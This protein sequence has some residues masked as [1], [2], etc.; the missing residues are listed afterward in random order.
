MVIKSDKKKII[1]LE[2]LLYPTFKYIVNNS[3]NRARML[4]LRLG[5]YRSFHANYKKKLLTP[6]VEE[7]NDYKCYCEGVNKQLPNDSEQLDANI[8]IV[9]AVP[10]YHKHVLLLSDIDKGLKNRF[11]VWRD[12]WESR[13]E[14]NNNFPYD[15]IPKLDF[16]PGI[17]FNA[18]SLVASKEDLP[19][20]QAGTYDFIVLPDL[21]L[22]RIRD[23]DIECFN[24]YINSNEV[25]SIPKLS[26]NDYLTGK[27]QV[28][29]EIEAKQKLNGMQIGSFETVALKNNKWTFVCGHRKRDERCGLVAPL[30]IKE[31]QRSID[32]MNLA[33]ISHIGGHKYAGNVIFYQPHSTS[34][35]KQCL[36]SLWFG[37]VTPNNILS[38]VRELNNGVIIENNFRGGVSL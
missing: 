38:L 18:I 7:S 13:I 24:N 31:L 6:T 33:I 17:L 20:P 19:M 1:L 25:K 9:K 26:F 3:E 4:R 36:D 8:E 11:P 10:E 27:A 34:Q 5:I 21:K 14:Q 30:L 35:N 29:I 22:Y 28:L 32:D 2:K 16:G 37:K 12:V 23:K 15:I